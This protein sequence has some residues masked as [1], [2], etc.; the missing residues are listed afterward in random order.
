[1]SA[2]PVFILG[3]PRSG[4][5]ILNQVLR[6]TLGYAGENEGHVFSVLKRMEDVLNRQNEF[7]RRAFPPKPVTTFQK[8]TFERMS[9]DVAGLFQTYV[10]EL[11]GDKPWQDKTPTHEMITFAPRLQELF[12]SVHFVFMKRRGIENL[13]SGQR[14]FQHRSFGELCQSWARSMESFAEIKDS[15]KNV[16]IIDQAELVTDPDDVSN[17]LAHFL[18]LNDT[19]AAACKRHFRENFPERT[20]PAR[21]KYVD[22]DDTGWSDEEKNQFLAVCGAQMEAWDYPLHASGARETKSL[23]RWCDVPK[24]PFV[25]TITLHPNAPDVPAPEAR[26]FGLNF[27]GIRRLKIE[28]VSNSKGPGAVLDATV[29]GADDFRVACSEYLAPGT[30]GT[31]FLDIPENLDAGELVLSAKLP[32]NVDSN[33]STGITISP[34]KPIGR[35]TGSKAQRVE[36]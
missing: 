23:N 27:V 16:L 3:A 30:R 33:H 19:S 1:M 4:T 24:D 29:V 14:K 18:G 35:N 22:L 32:E 5:S 7:V 36:T 6:E 8:L 31:L 28:A 15:L 13:L 17:R 25:E 21:T 20:H 34:I 9:N 26:Y 10:R 12:P 2:S 11:Y